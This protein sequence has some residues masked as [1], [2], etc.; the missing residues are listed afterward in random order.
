M[1]L[2]SLVAAFLMSA[3]SPDTALAYAEAQGRADRYKDDPVA[4]TWRNRQLAPALQAAAGPMLEACVPVNAASKPD[5][6]LVV[7]YKAGAFEAVRYTSDDPK[8]ACIVDYLAAMKW[9]APPHP[10]FA[11]LIHLNLNQK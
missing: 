8:A 7:S 4:V 11:E 1:I 3:A 6:S 9:P 2:T 5:F 10:D